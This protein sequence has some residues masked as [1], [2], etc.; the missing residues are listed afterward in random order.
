RR[1]VEVRVD[2]RRDADEEQ[3][4]H[5]VGRRLAGA[6]EGGEQRGARHDDV[7]SVEDEQARESRA[8]VAEVERQEER[9]DAEKDQRRRAQAG[10]QAQISEGVFLCRH[11]IYPNA[12]EAWWTATR[13]EGRSGPG[14]P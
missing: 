9:H 10:N 6:G 12:S 7:E 5:A 1:G 2:V 8:L 3:Q 11:Q 14:S 13:E 4:R